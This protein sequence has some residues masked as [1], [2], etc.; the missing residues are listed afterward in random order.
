MSNTP[1]IS[2]IVPVYNVEKYLRYCLDSIIEQTFQDWECICIDDGSFDNSGSILDEYEKKDNRFV[3]IHKKNGG[4]SSARNVGLD[5]AKG[6]WISFIDSDDILKKECF[7]CLI[8]ELNTHSG[9]GV[10]ET[11]Y[12]SFPFRETKQF[13]QDTLLNSTEWIDRVCLLVFTPNTSK[14]CPRTMLLKREVIGEERFDEQMSLYEDVFFYL[15]VISRSKTSIAVYRE[16]L[17][18]YRVRDGSLVRSGLS[19]KGITSAILL[20][21]NINKIIPKHQ[22]FLRQRFLL[23]GLLILY[24]L[25][26]NNKGSM[27]SFLYTDI[28]LLKKEIKMNKKIVLKNHSMTFKLFV[29]Y[30]LCLYFPNLIFRF[31]YK[32]I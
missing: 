18:L 26:K 15:S 16:E 25:V 30:M 12:R 22:E 23:S 31:K 24:V 8:S 2:I 1:K 5:I 20:A 13:Y 11:Y 29:K 3:V 10:L 7:S 32:R 28:N 6:E 4:V 19:V 17:Y 21:K 9:V 14:I 27:T